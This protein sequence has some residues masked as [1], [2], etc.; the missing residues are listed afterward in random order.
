MGRAY[1]GHTR[2]RLACLESNLPSRLSNTPQC[3]PPIRSHPFQ[4]QHSFGVVA[5][6]DAGSR[7]GRVA[8]VERVEEEDQDVSLVSFVR[9]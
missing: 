7:K 4:R 6:Q 3:C 9:H 2:P 8:T 5:R 1:P